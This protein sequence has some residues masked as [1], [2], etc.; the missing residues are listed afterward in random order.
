ML[1]WTNDSEGY[2]SEARRLELSDRS[3]HATSIT[4]LEASAQAIDRCILEIKA[5]ARH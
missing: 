1:K 2:R 3:R 4:M 5:S